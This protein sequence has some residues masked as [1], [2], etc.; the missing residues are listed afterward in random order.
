MR[1]RGTY[2]APRKVLNGVRLT[3]RQVCR[4]G[5]AQSVMIMTETTSLKVPKWRRWAN[6]VA[7]VNKVDVPAMVQAVGSAH[8]EPA[9]QALD[10]IVDLLEADDD[11]LVQADGLVPPSFGDWGLRG[12]KQAWFAKMAPTERHD[13]VVQPARWKTNLPTITHE[14]MYRAPWKKPQ[15]CQRVKLVKDIEDTCMW[16][17]ALETVY[18]FVKS[19]PMVRLVSAC[20]DVATPVVAGVDVGRWVSDPGGGATPRVLGRQLPLPPPSPP[21]GLRPTVSCQRCCPQASM[22]A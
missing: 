16:C 4:L 20:R 21:R 10:T 11:E 15:I 8:K 14:F 9:Q 3:A 13:V 17:G 1:S 22:G 6:T 5:L 18:H 7:E 12:V 2:S 19:S